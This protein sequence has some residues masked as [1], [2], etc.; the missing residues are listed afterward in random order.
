MFFLSF[1][2]K[3]EEASRSVIASCLMPPLVIAAVNSE[4]HVITATSSPF[5]TL[6]TVLVFCGVHEKWKGLLILSE[7]SIVL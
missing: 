7:D 5:L 2:K 6:K 1:L 4:D 3:V